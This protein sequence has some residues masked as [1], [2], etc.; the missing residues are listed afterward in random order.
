MLI[1]LT[2]K[3]VFDKESHPDADA[4]SILVS[5]REEVLV[6]IP[7]TLGWMDFVTGLLPYLVN[8][9]VLTIINYFT[10]AIHFIVLSKLCT[11]DQETAQTHN[12][13]MAFIS[14]GFS[15]G[16]KSINQ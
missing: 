15:K 4:H 2:S 11:G 14:I 6:I 16:F 3:N 12:Q 10:E 8:T 9:T 13:P 1:S 5:Y 7:L